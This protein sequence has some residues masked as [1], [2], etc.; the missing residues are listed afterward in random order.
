MRKLKLEIDSLAVESFAVAAGGAAAR[1][2]VRGAA[3][4]NL[5]LFYPQQCN[6]GGVCF[7]YPTGCPC[8]PRAG[9]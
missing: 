1:G 3:D 5:T 8:T 6:S 4:V 9:I 7:T 2:T